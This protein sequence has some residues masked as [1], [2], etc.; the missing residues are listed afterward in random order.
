[1][2]GGVFEQRLEDGFVV[3]DRPGDQR[4]AQVVEDI[5]EVPTT[6]G[7]T[8]AYAACASSSLTTGLVT[9]SSSRTARGRTERSNA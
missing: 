8:G 4:L 5:G 9:C 3:V 1:M 7:A 6:P 2:L